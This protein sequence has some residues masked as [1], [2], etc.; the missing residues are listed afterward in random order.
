MPS[1]FTKAFADRLNRLC[2]F[3][4]KE[5]ADGDKVISGHA[6]VAPGGFNMIVEQSNGETVIR[7]VEPS[8]RDRYVPSVDVM[9]ESLAALYGERLLA[10]VLTGMGNDGSKG[11]KAI[12]SGGG[13]I[14]AE[15]EESAIVFGMPREAIATKLVDKIVPLD[16]VAFEIMQ[17]AGDVRS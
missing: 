7:L 6:Y 16:A 4:I 12:K 8:A 17:A 14:F 3:P 5:S 10:V 13:Q 9:F 1:G 2:P 15:S 11:I